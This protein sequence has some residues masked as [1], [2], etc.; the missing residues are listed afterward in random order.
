MKRRLLSSLL[1][2]CMVITM[3]PTA[4][5]AAGDTGGAADSYPHAGEEFTVTLVGSGGP[6]D[7][8]IS[9]YM[10]EEDWY[11]M[12]G[13]VLM[14][15]GIYNAGMNDHNNSADKWTQLV[16]GAGGDLRISGQT[17]TENGLTVGETG[18][19]Q[20][21]LTTPITTDKDGMTYE[22]V[23]SVAN[24]SKTWA[25]GGAT[26]FY[27]FRINTTGSF[28]SIRIKG[29]SP[30]TTSPILIFQNDLNTV[31]YINAV[32]DDE[33]QTATLSS[34]G[35][36]TRRSYANGTQ[37]SNV[38]EVT[39]Q[40]N[41]SYVT[42]ETE[43]Y[44]FSS[45]SIP[46]STVQAED[47]VNDTNEEFVTL[48]KTLYGLRLYDCELSAA[49][50][51]QNAAVDQ[52]RFEDDTYVEP[53]TVQ[54]SGGKITL[55]EYDFEAEEAQTTVEG[56]A[57]TNGSAEL[58]LTLNKEGKYTLV[59]DVGGTKTTKEI[60][61]ISK[62][63]ADA[64]DEVISQISALPD[65]NITVENREAIAAAQEAYNDLSDD[66]KARV[67]TDLKDK[68]DACLA[69]LDN[70]MQGQ[71]I[72]VTLDANG[73]SWD[74]GAPTGV[75]LRYGQSGEMLPIPRR[76]LYNFDGWFVGDTR[77]TDADGITNNEWNYLSTT[78]LTAHWTAASQGEDGY[79][80]TSAEQI[81]A[82]AR[83][84]A[85]EPTNDEN[86]TEQLE[87]DYEMFGITSGYAEGY[88]ELQR[89]YYTLERD[90]TLTDQSGEYYGIPNFAGTFDGD[91]HT[92]TLNI[93]LPNTIPSASQFGGLI[94]SFCPPGGTVKNL[95][96]EGSM[97]SYSGGTTATGGL[98]DIGALAG[99]YVRVGSDS[100]TATIENVTSSVTMNLEIAT[101]SNANVYAGA[102][103]GRIYAAADYPSSITNCVNTG[104]LTARFTG[105][106]YSGGGRLGGLV[107][108]VYANTVMENCRNE[109]SV[110]TEDSQEGYRTNAGGL[111]GSGT[112]VYINCVQA[113]DVTSNGYRVYAFPGM[114]DGSTGNTLELTVTGTAGQV[115]A[116]GS[117]SFTLD[118]TNSVTFFIPVVYDG[119]TVENNGFSY[120]E[121]LTVDG[122]RL[123]WYNTTSTTLTANLNTS[124]AENLDTP[125][126]SWTDALVLM[127]EDHLVALQKA[128]NEGD[129]TSIDTLYQLGGREAPTNYE[130]ARLILQTAYYKLGNDIT[131]A[132]TAFT[133][134]G[135]GSYPF[136]GHL[137]GQEHTVTL[138][139]N[140]TGTSDSYFGL[141]G[142]ID[143]VGG[144]EAVLRS[145]KVTSTIT[146]SSSTATVYVG[147]L[148][149][150][151]NHN[152]LQLEDVAVTVNGITATS[153]STSTS[154]S[155]QVGGLFG[156]GSVPADSTVSLTVAGAISGTGKAGSVYAG[157][158]MGNGS[159]YS[160]ITVIFEDSA[161][162]TA[163][164]TGGA[165]DSGG[166]IGY[167]A[168]GS[169][170]LRGS[171]L[172]NNTSNAVNITSDAS[173]LAYA[174]GWVGQT[175][176]ATSAPDDWLYVDGTTVVT[177]D[178][179]VTA[180]SESSTANAGGI[181]GRVATSFSV[182]V[183]DYTNEIPV[184]GKYAGGLFG[185][186]ATGKVVTLNNSGNN[187]EIEGTSSYAGGLIA[188]AGSGT[189][190]VENCWNTG[191]VS[192][193]GAYIGGLVGT[194]GDSS[195]TIQNSLN[196]GSVTS[197]T[198]NSFVGGLVGL[199]GVTAQ[200]VT[201]T[202]GANG[203]ALSGTNCGGLI[204][205]KSAS[206]TVAYTNTLYLKQSDSDKA[207]GNSTTTETGAIA[208]DTTKLT[209][210]VYVG[211]SIEL[212]SADAPAVLTVEGGNAE[213]SGKNLYF[214][215]TGNELTFLWGGREL[216]KATVQVNVNDLEEKTVVITGVNSV[217]PSDT[218]AEAAMG[219]IQVYYNGRVLVPETDYTI[220]HDKDTKKFTVNFTGNY[221]GSAAK[222][223]TVEPGALEVTSEGY[224]GTYNG[225]LHGITVNVPE[226]AAV[227]YSSDG[228][229]YDNDNAP[230]QYQNAGTYVVYFKVTQ[231]EKK[232][233]GS[234]IISIDKTTITVTANSHSVTVGGAMPTLTYS[235]QGR[236]TDDNWI[237]EPMVSSSA[238]LDK[239]GTY[240]INVY[241]G[242][243]GSNYEI[244]YVSGTLT[245]REESEPEQP[246]VTP[247]D[248]DDDSRPSGGSS[249]SP[250]TRYTVSVDAGRNGDVT[251]S[252][253]RA[254]RGDTVTITVE[255][256]EGY[257]LD[258]LI[259]TDAD[260]DEI[261]V[262][263][264][265]NGRYTFTMP[266]GRVTVEAT[267]V[268]IAEEPETL[269]FVD[270][271]TGAYYYDAVAW[272][273]EN[274][275]TTGTSATTF[276][277]DIICTRAQMVTFLWRAAGSPE[278][279]S[280]V[281]P[282]TDVS[283]GAY[284]YDAVLWAVEQGITN[285]T[286]ASTFS[287]DATVTRGQTV[288]FLWRYDGSTA[289]SGSSFV[290][291][292]ADAYYADA[293]TWAASEGVTTGTSATTFSPDNDCTRAQI[294][295]FLYRYM[296]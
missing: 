233:T 75:V 150:R 45:I 221:S 1:A 143:V 252:P 12:D 88:D 63:D 214:T 136:G 238:D 130:E 245:V 97:Q 219:G 22:Q 234:Q 102:I 98:V 277:P 27:P 228:T 16:P 175:A 263:D 25:N 181:A 250:T 254:G 121:H 265:G 91:E 18:V 148:A 43:K 279:E 49:E 207:V 65:S 23:F 218:A 80:I 122:T 194:A 170:D 96:L 146:A 54:A 126:Q 124:T 280:T 168:S 7:V 190:T 21:D 206:S 42:S 272:A 186:L 241:G 105:T 51:A 4:A 237:V 291:V 83:I 142:N 266:R 287:P 224:S 58:T 244:E 293:V 289:V 235:D 197:N 149:G 79:T 87:S 135:S 292:A 36:S 278:P 35:N 119:G 133:G 182:L 64:A 53:G 123:D 41:T 275:I 156:S 258:E 243:A 242:D 276:G 169:V 86:V 189:V 120:D 153:T 290:D 193:P 154:A 198:T 274:D 202:N 162:V 29:G 14:Y 195:L 284:Y 147:G 5:L 89:A 125:F 76:T 178:F 132:D 179:N 176:A 108:H 208:M 239:A 166:L 131:V 113:G 93:T 229:S 112:V 173:S 188:A 140:L 253:S 81:Y 226:G 72:S 220:T 6:A 164:N 261:T 9:G 230:I 10:D 216:Y 70:V 11:V 212:L 61:V 285:G 171:K 138:T 273:V 215:A 259:V 107:G 151:I 114:T 180:T 90:I 15:D 17:W 294:V 159:V 209:N 177:G 127:T 200:D 144:S 56:V 78:E 196:T 47:Y 50:I 174:G 288:T 281:N 283:A 38:S 69:A 52:A 160:P 37:K 116:Y 262:R 115:V 161:A 103:I 34:D 157:G 155:L 247:G 152:A 205:S 99:G 223:Y 213:F 67:G 256:D 59:F 95:K 60:T 111:A 39:S 68:L 201:L 139:L 40:G 66:A 2:L 282:F 128:I 217:Y 94:A 158:A 225:Q 74:G 117:Q 48:D 260:G 270:V 141:F 145:L 296:G 199:V 240:T 71:E 172:V 85:E 110:S 187:A 246:P 183:M 55:T 104:N 210:T 129:E 203:G 77:I 33:M 264:R 211:D 101:Q 28:G 26:Y 248:D 44:S 191:A 134:I 249:S 106:E 32:Q 204:G 295:T 109:G 227:T 167:F 30:S 84:L 231:G 251:V 57:F 185:D 286:S 232:V 192:T 137:D 8:T 92:I 267:F 19:S 13:L 163:K 184:T 257:E 24:G 271:P 236:V 31:L 268:E 165:A 46:K 62:N 20:V 269:P 255:P 82:L 118:G 3:L 100:G 222:S 73:G